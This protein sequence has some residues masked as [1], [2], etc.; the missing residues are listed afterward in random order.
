MV[1]RFIR[2]LKEEGVRRV[3]APLCRTDFAREV[4]SFFTWYNE[5]WPHA[6]LQGKTPNEDHFSLRPA[7]RRLRIEPRERWPRS[8]PCV[9]PLT[10]I[11]DPPG[12]RFV[13]QIKFHDNKRHLPKLAMK[14]A[15]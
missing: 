12:N 5:C 14:P 1:E 4:A 8:A 9:K 13:V 2:T 11:V 6:M 10:L 15:A 7:T 3:L